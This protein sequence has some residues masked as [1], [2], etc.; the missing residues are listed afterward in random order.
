[1][2]KYEVKK[3]KKK[4]VKSNFSN[5]INCVEFGTKKL[6]RQERS[7]FYVELETRKLGG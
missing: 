5:G 7:K 4:E 1:M 3:E 6:G 2:V